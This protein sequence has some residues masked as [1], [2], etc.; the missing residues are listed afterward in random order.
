[1]YRGRLPSI[2]L[3]LAAQ[4]A[5]ALSWAGEPDPTRARIGANTQ[6]IP[7]GLTLQ[8]G[9]TRAFEHLYRNGATIPSL[10][11][12]GRVTR[13]E[14]AQ[15]SIDLLQVG[16]RNDGSFSVT[17]PLLRKQA[18]YLMELKYPDQP[19]PHRFK[20][21]LFYDA[22]PDVPEPQAS[23]TT[24]KPGRVSVGI[25]AGAL[26][27]DQTEYSGLSEKVL[28]LSLGFRH[29]PTA[30]SRWELGL[31]LAGTPLAFGSSDPART[32][33]T[34]D[35]RGTLAFSLTDA[36]ARSDVPWRLKVVT[37]FFFATTFSD[38][39]DLGYQNARGPLLYPAVVRRWKNGTEASASARFSPF[40]SG[41]FGL[42]GLSSRE[43][44][45]DATY[46]FAPSSGGTQWGGTA[47]YSDLRLEIAGSTV[48]SRTI[49][50]GL[51]IRP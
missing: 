30:R 1:M 38:D 17:L 36:P 15:L 50:G 24:G 26:S 22:G 12:R 2:L 21:Y 5:S 8:L 16:L 4:L 14:G 47:A 51:V 42:I 32:L 45:V 20:I 11:L 6:E 9:P 27:F 43:I 41:Q 18:T 37:G 31:D 13:L 46:W 33:H 28:R 10:S 34:L 40:F 23:R 48:S 7:E 3:L 29:V 25:G 49:W 39:A 44:A 19:V 35:F